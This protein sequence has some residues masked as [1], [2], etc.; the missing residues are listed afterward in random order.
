MALYEL[1]VFD[2]SNPVL[3]PMWRQCM[4]VIAFITRLG[5][6][7]SWGGWSITR[8]AITNPSIWSY[9]GVAGAHIENLFRIWVSDPYGLT[10][11]VQLVN[12]TWG[13]K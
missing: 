9:E 5:K 2:P 4:F 11:K 8:G 7:N 3:D 6:T 13:M 1:A 12:L 10:D